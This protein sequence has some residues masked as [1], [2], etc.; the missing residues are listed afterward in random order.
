M[1]NFFSI[2]IIISTALVVPIIIKKIHFITVPVIVGEII[3][4]II[5]GKGGLNLIEVNDNLN[6]LY[7]LGFAFLMFLSGL[8]IDTGLLLRS[9]NDLESKTW[10][11]Q[12]I[13]IAILFFCL[14]FILS[15]LISW[16]LYKLRIID[17]VII[18]SLIFSNS[19]LG[20]VAPTLKEKNIINTKFGQT[21]LMV[22]VISDVITMILFSLYISL[23]NN[24]SIYQILSI[25]L[26][27][28]LFILLKKVTHLFFNCDFM[29][30]ISESTSQIYIRYSYMILIFFILITFFLKTLVI[31]GAFLAGYL[32]SLVCENMEDNF[33]KNL[34]AIGYGI[35][36][37][38]AFILV[39]VKFDLKALFYVNDIIWILFIIIIS[40]FIVK[41]IPGIILNTLYDSIKSLSASF[42]LSSRLSLVIVIASISHNNHIIDDGSNGIIITV[43]LLTCIISPFLFNKFNLSA[44]GSRK[45]FIK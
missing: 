29:K 12:P 14:N 5:L 41:V 6:L 19:A 38:S 34:D 8:Q 44:Q 36:I 40:S 21:I 39:G 45:V 43:A 1:A 25:L 26:F 4:G 31:I 20:V 27:I 11:K 10:Y 16:S 30:D 42:I 28:P 7:N 35:F 2:F 37:P 15:V 24:I 33:F 17:N 13:Y 18:F 3:A 22:T 23:W 32:I 9:D